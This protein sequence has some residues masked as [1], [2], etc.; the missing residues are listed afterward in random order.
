MNRAQDYIEHMRTA[1]RLA[2]SYTE[3]MHREDF[4][5]D[6]RTQ[7][8]TVMN[9]IIIGEAASK[10]LSENPQLVELY[11]DVAWRNMRGMRNRLAHGY[12]EIDMDV[13]WDTLQT[14]LPELIDRLDRVPQILLI[15][16]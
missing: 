1:A 7:Q 5:A 15:S 12:F 3:G 8:A 16:Q 2:I 6:T 4:L 10:L 11:P 14:A 9:L 13:V